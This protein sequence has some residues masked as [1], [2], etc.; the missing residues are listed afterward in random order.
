VIKNLPGVG[1]N[2]QD[3]VSINIT[4]RA[5]SEM[6]SRWSCESSPGQ[7]EAAR[8][9]WT[10]KKT[11]PLNTIYSNVNTFIMKLPSLL[12]SHE[13][14]ALDPS[15]CEFLGQETV[16]HFEIVAVRIPKLSTFIP[17]PF[18]PHISPH[19]RQSILQPLANLRAAQNSSS[20]IP[21]APTP[22]S[23]S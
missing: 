17:F 23:P 12:D 11:G 22:T 15:T 1:K 2:F 9:E 18:S 13:F 5:S 3:H 4:S 16:S 20:L 14:R 21:T 6:P 8:K 10:E 7:Q 19:H